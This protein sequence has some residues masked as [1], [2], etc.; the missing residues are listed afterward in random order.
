[1][2]YF[3][4]FLTIGCLVLISCGH[5]PPQVSAVDT[6]VTETTAV[7]PESVLYPTYTPQPTYTLQPTYTPLPTYTSIPTMVNSS[8]NSLIQT[9]LK[10]YPLDISYDPNKWVSS[11]A[12]YVGVFLINV[13]F[14]DCQIQEIGPSEP[15]GDDKGTIK[16]D[17]ITYDLSETYYNSNNN[18]LYQGDFVALSGF[19]NMM[20]DYEPFLR[21]TSSIQNQAGCL[22]EARAVLSSLK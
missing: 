14:P 4:C 17:S 21:I 3:L 11:V 13:D 9:R 12:D 8:T 18:S 6:A 2:K 19:A 1:M 22:E 5:V 16:L 10:F 20:P 15:Q 7:T